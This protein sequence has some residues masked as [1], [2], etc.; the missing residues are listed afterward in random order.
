[1]LIDVAIPSDRNIIQ[2]EAECKLKYKNLG[3]ESQQTWNIK[4][5]I[6]LI[7]IGAT[8]AVIKLIKISGN[9][10]REALNIFSTK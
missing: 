6:V 4:S 9:N 8:G 2:K 1:M 5:V 3:T 10:T 7:N